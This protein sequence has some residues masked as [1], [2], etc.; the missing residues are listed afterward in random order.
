MSNARYKELKYNGRTYTEKYQIDEI[1]LDNN[2]NWF[3]DCEV[4]N[5]RFEIMK[6]TIIIN[7]G[8]FYNGIFEYGVIRDIDCRNMTFQNG[9]IYNGVFKRIKMEKGIIFNGTFIKG[10]IL[11]SDIRG[12]EFKDV[13]ISD[14][15]NKTQKES[16]PS[17]QEPEKIQPQG[18]PT[19]Q[20]Q[21]QAQPQ[22]QV[23]VQGEIQ[24]QEGQNIQSQVQEKRI[25]KT[26]E[27]FLNEGKI[28][29]FF[30]KIGQIIKKMWN[31]PAEKQKIEIESQE[32]QKFKEPI[33]DDW[34]KKQQQIKQQLIE[35]ANEI[36]DDFV[37]GFEKDKITW[38]RSGYSELNQIWYKFKNNDN[39]YFEFINGGK[40]SFMK[41]NK[42][43]QIIHS[44][45]NVFFTQAF[46][47]FFGQLYNYQETNKNK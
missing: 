32:E 14:N 35:T 28:N 6:D 12:G 5:I 24:G 10:D 19:T 2:F 8:I 21:S 1:L 25:V 44:N 13:N 47:N 31:N 26:F 33:I 20:A 40:G 29:D 30:N 15:V 22:A 11:F 7:G 4:E 16:Q 9:V 45:M 34:S 41:Y 27:S 3:F 42:N 46:I 18:E 38:K 36:K 43:N 23:Q 17:L 39:I 37:K